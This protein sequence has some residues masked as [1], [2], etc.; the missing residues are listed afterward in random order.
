MIFPQPPLPVPRDDDRLASEGLFTK[1]ILSLGSSV[2]NFSR[3]DAADF[4]RQ[5]SSQLGPEDC[6]IVGLD[7]CQDSQTVYEAY[8]DREGVTHAFSLNGLRHANRLL[9]FEAF[10]LKNLDD[11]FRQS[12]ASRGW[13]IEFKSLFW[14]ELTVIF[15]IVEDPRAPSVVICKSAVA[16]CERFCHS[17]EVILEGGIEG[18]WKSEVR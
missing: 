6:M 4:I 10:R 17:S 7:G 12:R 3:D 11:V 2:G 15:V 18:R 9:G 14:Q 16:V 13:K 1:A 8:N 5:F